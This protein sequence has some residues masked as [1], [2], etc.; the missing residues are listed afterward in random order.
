MNKPIVFIHGSGDSVLIWRLQV[1][2]FGT[3]QAFPIDLP[4]H[5]RR[6]ETLADRGDGTGL[7]YVTA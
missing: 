3:Q 6:P 5:G 4:G 2:H 7:V 1:E